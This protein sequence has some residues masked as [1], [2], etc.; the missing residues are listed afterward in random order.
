MILEKKTAAVW[1]ALLSAMVIAGC[2]TNEPLKKSQELTSTQIK[3]L[4]SGNTLYEEGYNKGTHWQWAGYYLADGTIYARSWWNGGDKKETG[5]WSVKKN[6]LF[7]DRLDKNDHNKVHCSHVFKQGNVLIFK[8][9]TPGR[10]D[11]RD[12]LLAG[13]PYKLPS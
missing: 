2:A 4:L 9:T 7:C 11:F 6:G 10:R 13:N 1:M 5:T 12:K 8:S 3:T